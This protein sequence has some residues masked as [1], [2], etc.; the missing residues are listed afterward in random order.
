MARG[1]CSPATSRYARLEACGE[2]NTIY[3]SDDLP[4]YLTVL[5][6]GHVFVPM[7]MWV[8][9]AYEPSFALQAA[10]WLP[11]VTLACLA[12]LPCAKGATVG[13]CWANNLVRQEPAA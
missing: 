6:V 3:P 12:L 4:P 11:L 10:I 7:F 2:D 13:V 5:V 1:A 8:D 9:R